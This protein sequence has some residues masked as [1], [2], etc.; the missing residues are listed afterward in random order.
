VDGAFLGKDEGER[1]QEQK[2]QSRSEQHFLKKHKNEG[3][4]K[5]EEIICNKVKKKIKKRKKRK[6]KE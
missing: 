1:G 3:E 5:K 2:E 4:T 6:S